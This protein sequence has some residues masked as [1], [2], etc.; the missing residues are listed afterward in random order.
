M[1]TR[2]FV[3]AHYRV[4]VFLDEVYHNVYDFVN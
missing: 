4:I 2:I 3:L 1:L